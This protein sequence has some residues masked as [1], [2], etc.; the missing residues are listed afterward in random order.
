MRT[1]QWRVAL[2]FTVLS[3][4]ALSTVL[5]A[6]GAISAWLAISVLAALTIVALSVWLFV[7]A[8][9]S[10]SVRA[11]SQAAQ[12]VARGDLEYR[13]AAP[14]SGEAR[15]L[16]GAFNQVAAV[17]EDAVGNLT[18]ERNKLTALLDLMADGVLVIDRDSRVSLLNRAAEPLLEVHAA[19]VVGS[20][21]A[22]VVR[23]H[24]LLT[25]VRRA[26]GSGQP[27]QSDVELIAN[28]RFVRA[29]AIPVQENGSG[30]VLLTLQ[31]LT[32]MQRLD[33]T[34]REFV[35]NVSHELRGPLASI[36]AMVETLANGAFDDKETAGEFLDRIDREVD[37]MTVMA[38]ELLELSLLESGQVDLHLS[39]LPLK[40][41]ARDV[42]AQVSGRAAAAGIE[43]IVDMPNSL[44]NVVGEEEK[45]R[46]VLANLVENAIK[47]MPEGGRVRVGAAVN[48]RLVEVS[49]EDT[50]MGIPPEHLPHV[51]ERFYKVDRSRR[52]GGTGLGLAIVKHIVQLHGGDVRAESSE[53]VGTTF[54]FAIPRA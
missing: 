53:G 2:P 4:V 1:L 22:E 52:E 31:D 48:G 35:S 43:T 37:R 36:K 19:N 42:M 26:L 12:R 23:D 54:Y 47:F 14:A 13:M 46:Q 21:V 7:A 45:L 34:R 17:M 9:I 33:T 3:L 29:L 24:E 41:I 6:A 5:T 27:Y 11:L 16:A 38:N 10:R 32:R 39:P 50:G 20:G 49:V 51:F 40:P 15:D 30:G 28:R 8:H 18:S 44:P 25:L